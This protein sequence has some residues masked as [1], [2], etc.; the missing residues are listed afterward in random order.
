MTPSTKIGD[1]TLSLVEVKQYVLEH[2]NGKK[3]NCKLAEGMSI[4]V[5]FLKIRELVN[6]WCNRCKTQV[7]N[8]SFISIEYQKEIKRDK[9]R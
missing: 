9:Y 7:L 8:P 3:K 4:V 5:T 2:T 1:N 6:E